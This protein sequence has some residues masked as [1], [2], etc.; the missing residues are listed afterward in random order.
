LKPNA[1][2][3]TGTTPVTD[4]QAFNRTGAFP[5]F[6]T[7]RKRDKVRLFGDWS[8]MDRVS[9][10][11]QVEDGR[12][13]YDPP[14]EKGINGTTMH[15]YG[16]DVSYAISDNWKLTG[17]ASYVEQTLRVA[18]STG[19][20]AD[21][22]DRNN[23]L[24]VRLVGTPMPRFQMGADFMWIEDRNIYAQ[25]L[26]P[27]ASAAN[28]AFLQQ[29]GGLPNVVWRDLRLKFF[30]TY[31]LQKNSDIR[32]D[33]VHDRQRLNEWTWV[34]PTNGVPYV[35][36]DNTTVILNPKQNVTFISASYIYRFR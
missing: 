34:N 25:A 3:L 35:Y 32:F 11:V 19:Y 26:D 4:A 15:L 14:S 28:I 31:N 12:D 27:Q 8:P 7:N 2:P 36:S 1:L 20:I 16:L 10:Q 18:H 5:M 13:H 24:G 6:F 23:T 22:K 29:S 17:Y 21:L 30:G 33:V 9:V